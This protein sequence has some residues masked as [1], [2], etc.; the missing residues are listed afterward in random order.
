MKIKSNNQYSAEF[1]NSNA[2]FDEK[3]SSSGR[4]IVQKEGEIDLTTT[5]LDDSPVLEPVITGN[6]SRRNKTTN[7][8]RHENR[9]ELA[10]GDV[11]ADRYEIIPELWPFIPAGAEVSQ[12]QMRN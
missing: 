11:L 2:P 3:D 9:I 6:L 12:N 1:R 10:Q 8:Y 4:E 7:S 5:Q